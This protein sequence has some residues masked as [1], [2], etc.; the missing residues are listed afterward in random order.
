MSQSSNNEINTGSLV[1][2]K[3]HWTQPA[4]T[5]TTSQS[6]GTQT[7]KIRFVNYIYTNISS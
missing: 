7:F 4:D 3:D 6:S 1:F 5:T 2:K